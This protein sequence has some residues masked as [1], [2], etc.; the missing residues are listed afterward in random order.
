MRVGE[1][2]IVGAGG[3]RPPL[4]RP[5]QPRAARRAAR[6]RGARERRR[7]RAAL[8]PAQDLRVRPRL[9][10]ARRARGRAREPPA[11]GARHVQG[12]GDAAPERA[13]ASSRCC[14]R[15]PTARSSA[16]SRPRRAPRSTTTGSSCCAR[17]RSS[18]PSSRA[19]P[20]RSSA[21]RRR[22]AISLRE[23]SRALHKASD[24][25]RPRAYEAL[26][27]TWF[28]RLLGD[29]RPDV[30]SSY[31]TAW[32]RR[33]SPLESTYTKDRAT[34]ICLQTLEAL[35]FDLNAQPNIKLD[36][37]D[38]PQKSP[39]ACV[40]ASDPPKVVHLITRAQ[41]G[42]HDYQAFLHEAGH[43]LHYARLRP[44]PAVHLPAHRARP[45]ADRDLLVH[46]RGDLARARVA[47]ALLRPLA[48]AGARERRGDD[49]PRGA[50]LPPL[51]GEAA[52][53]A[54]LLVAVQRRRRRRG[55]L[56]AAASPRRRACATA[57]RPTSPTWMRASTRP[58]TCARGS[59][60]RSCAST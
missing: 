3:D 13:G 58:T 1:K 37:D 59:A 9:G 56:R 16:R 32:M 41:G 52:L 5:L 39:R 15:T 43:A 25:L 22:R 21:T 33:L 49:V 8:P 57:R 45:R 34:E 47:R 28:A 26:R 10:R 42:L 18:P 55:R 2:E 27:A 11:R 23:L 4:R 17:P 7:A 54:R 20:T 31:H 12:R 19:S 24:R 60:R 50:A 48:R 30:P 36:L 40:I 6:G 38:R 29:D 35:G 51:R 44:E 53:R 14:R 46:R